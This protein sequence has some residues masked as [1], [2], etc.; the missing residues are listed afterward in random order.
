M[1]IQFPG[2]AVPTQEGGISYRAIVDGVTV[3][4]QFT[5]EALQ[6][7][8]PAHTQE[9][10]MNQFLFSQGQL[11]AIAEAKI[12][13]GNVTNGIIHVRASDVRT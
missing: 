6:D 10:P 3:A 8:N 2:P 5:W 1:N 9:Q 11:L 7:V 12:R 4:C 13:A